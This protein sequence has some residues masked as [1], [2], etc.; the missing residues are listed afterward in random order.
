MDIC[1]SYCLK[2]CLE[3]LEEHLDNTPKDSEIKQEKA[4]IL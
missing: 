3:K 1:K 4:Y 2:E